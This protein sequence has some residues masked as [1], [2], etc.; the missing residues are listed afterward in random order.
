MSGPGGASDAGVATG[1]STSVADRS[2]SEVV[3]DLNES[4]SVE[5]ARLARETRIGVL[6]PFGATVA[7]F[8]SWFFRGGRW[9]SGVAG[10]VDSVLAAMGR[11]VMLIKAYIEQRGGG[12]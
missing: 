6:A 11:S 5:A 8:S 7:V 4:T 2:I 3:A 9:K 1:R 12:R 10:F